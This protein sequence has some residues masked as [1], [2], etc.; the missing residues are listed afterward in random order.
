VFRIEI[1]CDITTLCLRKTSI[2]SKT[3]ARTSNPTC[4]DLCMFNFLF[5]PVKNLNFQA[6]KRAWQVLLEARADRTA[7]H[8][9]SCSHKTGLA[10]RNSR[11]VRPTSAETCSRYYTRLAQC[12]QHC[13]LIVP[14]RRHLV[15][16]SWYF[17]FA[18]KLNVDYRV[19]EFPPVDP[20]WAV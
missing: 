8:H 20:L 1:F 9:R 10:C 14:K 19:P 17:I 5:I 4:N 12:N 15:K 7:P 11:L 6:N 16:R 2:Y 18:C 13:K 3:A